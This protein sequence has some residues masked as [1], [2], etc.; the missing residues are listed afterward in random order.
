M[1]SAEAAVHPSCVEPWDN[2]F[3]ATP[4]SCRRTG[5]SALPGTPSTASMESLRCSAATRCQRSSCAALCRVSMRLV[6]CLEWPCVGGLLAV[7]A[8]V[9]G[10]VFAATLC[11]LDKLSQTG[12]HLFPIKPCRTPPTAGAGGAAGVWAARHRGR[13][14]QAAQRHGQAVWALLWQ[15]LGGCGVSGSDAGWMWWMQQAPPAAASDV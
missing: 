11:M 14:Q 12:T 13:R 9:L 6:G 1:R 2:S 7:L 4:H 5:A 15:A 3:P 10:F 8:F